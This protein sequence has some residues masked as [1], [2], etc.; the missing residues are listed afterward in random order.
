MDYCLVL[1]V[2]HIVFFK[3]SPQM[4]RSDTLATP[5]AAASLSLPVSYRFLD[6]R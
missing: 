3:F 1:S 4:Q 2:D 6:L 5:V